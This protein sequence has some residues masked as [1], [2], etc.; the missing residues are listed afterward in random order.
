[1][2]E[3]EIFFSIFRPGD[4]SCGEWLRK[5]YRQTIQR[6]EAAAQKET[7]DGLPQASGSR[8][9]IQTTTGK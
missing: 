9:K 2:A 8:K 7:A 1:M 6:L 5:P 4:E 3:G